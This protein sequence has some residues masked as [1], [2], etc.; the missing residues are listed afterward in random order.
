MKKLIRFILAL[1]IS[2]L[3]ALFGSTSA[4]ADTGAPPNGEN[5]G[6]RYINAPT[7]GGVIGTS[8]GTLNTHGA[9]M[10]SDGVGLDL[11]GQ[12]PNNFVINCGFDFRYSINGTQ[13]VPL[14]QSG[15]F[16]YS[17][18]PT[19]TDANKD[20]KHC[21]GQG[22]GT[23]GANGPYTNYNC[24]NTN[25]YGQSF[26]PAASGTL[27]GFSMAMT[28]M[29]TSGSTNLTAAIYESTVPVKSV[30][31][32]ADSTITSTPLATAT[33]TMTGCDTT[34]SGKAFSDADF[35][36]PT[37]D[38]G[39]LTLDSSKWYTV[40]FAGNAVAG[41]RPSGVTTSSNT[42][43][44]STAPTISSG[45]T[46]PSVQVGKTAVETYKANETVTWKITGGANN[47]L[48]TINTNTGELS[49]KKA[50][51]KAGKYVV[52]IQA[53]DS[54]GNVGAATTITVTVKSTLAATGA[55]LSL[56][57][58]LAAILIGALMVGYSRSARRS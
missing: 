47:S 22:G 53:T 27:S 19:I 5:I 20:L 45:S 54:A 26:I 52:I 38:F 16:A 36:Y 48:F 44:D 6:F 4:Q 35:T 11:C 42:T 55:N 24:F 51:T 25:T 37:M 40:L 32:T 10:L 43:T 2:G 57:T 34:W 41:A 56:A 49:F 29:S 58:P 46:T 17:V 1:S 31:Q 33:F 23:N 12:S 9:F 14:A 21:S 50:P 13:Y 15:A 7:N 8:D 3:V 28:C 30:S 39:A 18:W